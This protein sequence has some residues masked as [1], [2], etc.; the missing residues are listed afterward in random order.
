MK[1]GK[2]R[3]FKGKICEVIFLAKDSETSENMVVYNE[4]GI[5][6]VRSEKMFLENIKGEGYEGPRFKYIGD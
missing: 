3:H 6:W 2:Y 4:D 1:L 5:I